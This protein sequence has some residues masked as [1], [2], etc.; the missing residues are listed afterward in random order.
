MDYTAQGHTVGLVQRI[1]QLAEPGVPHL[2][3]HTARLVDG[4]M[5]LRALGDFTIKGAKER[6]AVY[7]LQVPGSCA[8]AS[9]LREPA[10]CR[11]SSAAKEALRRY[12]NQ[13]RV[14]KG[15]SFAVRMGLNSRRGRGREDRRLG[16]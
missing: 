15:I 8:L 16:A 14:E 4:Y 3:A 9:T 7:A 12:A 10:A 1:E 5:H 13:L 6:L 11:S 2:T